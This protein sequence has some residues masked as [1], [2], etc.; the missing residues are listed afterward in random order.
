MQTIYVFGVTV[1]LISVAIFVGSFALWA[2]AVLPSV[3]NKKSAD[4][5]ISMAQ[6]FRKVSNHT[7]G[8][9]FVTGFFLAYYRLAP[10]IE[11]GPLMKNPFTHMFLTK[12]VFLVGMLV[13]TILHN[14]MFKEEAIRALKASPNDVIVKASK[15]ARINLILCI[16]I[17]ALGVMLVRGKFW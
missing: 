1:H 8:L 4:F 5:F 12:V 2:A 13:T 7:L 10:I 14:R 11:S 9:I 16:I 6:R 3:A 17:I 15:L